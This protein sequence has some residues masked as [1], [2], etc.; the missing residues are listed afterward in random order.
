[1]PA[2]LEREGGEGVLLVDP[3][4]PVAQPGHGEHAAPRRVGALLPGTPD[5]HSKA[6]GR[7]CARAHGVRP[8]A[9]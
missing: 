2:V 9:L 1:M 5:R 8:Q 6:L 4:D 3:D 7:G